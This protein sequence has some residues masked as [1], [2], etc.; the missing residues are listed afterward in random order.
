M[1]EILGPAAIATQRDHGYYAT[2]GGALTKFTLN[3]VSW[4]SAIG[5]ELGHPVFTTNL[6]LR[7]GS[8]QT[9]VLTL[10][11]PAGAGTPVV[12]AQPMVCPMSIALKAE[13]CG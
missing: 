8:T 10:T 3:D 11:E 2:Q 9:I 13:T 5:S 6:A 12:L 7:R 4:T 1:R